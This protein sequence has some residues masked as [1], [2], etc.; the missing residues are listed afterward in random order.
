MLK[1][2]FAC[3]ARRQGALRPGGFGCH[4][5]MH[6]AGMLAGLTE[7]QPR[8]QSAVLHDPRW[9]EFGRQERHSLAAPLSRTARLSGPCERVSELRWSAPREACS[10]SGRRPSGRS[11]RAGA[12]ARRLLGQRIGNADEADFGSRRCGAPARTV[13]YATAALRA[14]NIRSK[15]RR[16]MAPRT[17]LDERFRTITRTNEQFGAIAANLSTMH[18]L[19]MGVSVRL[20]EVQASTSA[21]KIQWLTRREL[22]DFNVTNAVREADDA[23]R[24]DGSNRSRRA[25]SL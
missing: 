16:S 20:F 2:G 9:F 8:N 15:W 19:K 11:R 1:R 18:L 23:P 22:R 5:A 24:T 12:E 3:S 25:L 6:I 4:E 21:R 13:R 14:A 7:D 17:P 10:C